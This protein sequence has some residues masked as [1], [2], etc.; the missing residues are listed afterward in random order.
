MI[1]T[2]VATGLAGL[3][4]EGAAY[5]AIHTRSGLVGDVVHTASKALHTVAHSVLCALDECGGDIV[6][7]VQAGSGHVRGSVEQAAGR[8]VDGAQHTSTIHGA[9]GGIATIL[10]SR[11]VA[12]S[13]AGR[14]S[15]IATGLT[16]ISHLFL[17]IATKKNAGRV[18]PFF[19]FCFFLFFCFRFS[20]L[21]PSTLAQINQIH[22][23][24]SGF[25]GEPR[26]LTLRLGRQ[27]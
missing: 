13:L 19:I 14:S 3:A 25:V 23:C 6:C 1:A 16:V 10:A 18:L 27:C 21:C 26:N 15:A 9:A 11:I 17:F 5:G 2:G 20:F 4:A 12:A 22:Q 8:T 7:S 24:E